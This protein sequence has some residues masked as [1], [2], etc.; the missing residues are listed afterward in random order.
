MSPKEE[1]YLEALKLA[2][3]AEYDEKAL[4]EFL[5]GDWH[6]K[7]EEVNDDTRLYPRYKVDGIF[8]SAFVN[9]LDQEQVIL[10]NLEDTGHVGY[11][12]EKNLVIKGDTD[13][14]LGRNMIQGSITV[15]NTTY[16]VGADSQGGEIIV[17]GNLEEIGD[18]CDAEVHKLEDGNKMRANTGEKT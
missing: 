3:E 2:G 12:N 1:K 7:F 9:N 17:E 18:Q 4:Q 13:T 15:E 5:S 8:V 14:N 10:P 6:E 16:F 11:R